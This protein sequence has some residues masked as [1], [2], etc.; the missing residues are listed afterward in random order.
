[1][2]YIQ[3]PHCEK[4]YAANDTIK[5]SVGKKIRCKQCK[6]PFEIIVQQRPRKN[7]A[8]NKP[9]KNQAAEQN[10][11]VEETVQSEGVKKPSK[12]SEPAKEKRSNKKNKKNKKSAT[13]KKRLNTQLIITSVLVITL[14]ITAIVGFLFFNNPELF[15][16]S[17]SKQNS[18]TIQPLIPDFDPFAKGIGP[19][20]PESKKE[21]SAPSEE[22]KLKD[23]GL[24][25]PEAEQPKTDPAPG[26]P[27]PDSSEQQTVREN[28]PPESEG[29]K[30]PTQA[31]KDA[32]S[33]RWISIYKLSHEK[34]NSE[35]YMKLFGQGAGQTAE[36]RKLCKDNSLVT[37]LTSAA[38]EEKIPEWIRKE[39]ETRRD[40]EEARKKHL[41]E[42]RQH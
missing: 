41:E 38:R 16:A 1:M 30:N 36:V 34:L 14:I 17:E 21:E 6:E 13:G 18:K 8:A 31:C 20:A 42:S 15:Q 5:A 26:I 40:I 33:I 9:E 7:T 29:P 23:E 24:L 37:R 10:K 27:E 12:A 28:I 11:A 39:I 3:C 2:E 25:A 4:K 19:A 32:A 35:T 22:E